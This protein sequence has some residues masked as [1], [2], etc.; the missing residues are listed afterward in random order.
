VPA[1]AVTPDDEVAPNRPAFTTGYTAVFTVRNLGPSF[2]GFSISCIGTGTVTCTGRTPAS[3]SMG[4]GV[5]RTVTAF[6]NVGNIGTGTIRVWATGG[7]VSD[8][9]SYIVTAV[10][11]AGAPQV[12]ATPYNYDK[13]DYDRCAAACF[14]AIH[15]QGTVPYISLDAPRS[16]SL[17]YNG[18]RLDP[19]AFAHVNVTPDHLS[20]G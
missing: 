8:T 1:V 11:P 2:A 18:D 9:G 10:L 14:S 7:G 15:A 17:L 6:Y 3:V 4:S 12:D 19:K 20:T 13:Q 16:V 5:E